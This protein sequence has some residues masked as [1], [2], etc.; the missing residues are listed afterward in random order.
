MHVRDPYRRRGIASLLTHA[1]E[2]EAASLGFDRVRLQ[3][4]A[5]DDGPQALYRHCGYVDAGLPP[6]RVYGTIQLR[7]GPIFVDDTLLTWEKRLD[8]SP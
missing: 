4:S 5:A 2:Q 6:E 1:I 3:V 7:T 8:V